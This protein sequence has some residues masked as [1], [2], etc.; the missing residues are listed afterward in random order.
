VVY[1]THD[2]TSMLVADENGRRCRRRDD[3][4]PLEWFQQPI[5]TATRRCARS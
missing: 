5:I 4:T 2:V 1:Q 3:A